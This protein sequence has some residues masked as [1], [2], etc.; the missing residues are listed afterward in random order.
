[1]SV[2]NKHQAS[3]LRPQMTEVQKRAGTTAWQA[4]RTA[5][6]NASTGIRACLQKVACGPQHLH[7]YQYG[8]CGQ[9]IW[10]PGHA[11]AHMHG[12]EPKI[13][14]HHH[15]RPVTL[16]ARIHPRVPILGGFIGSPRP[17]RKMS[18]QVHLA[19]DVRS[20]ELLQC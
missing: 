10:L 3:G 8:L 4:E 17:G 14:L 6:D 2:D 19:F 11:C 18:M 16:Q 1:M 12:S 7:F 5:N 15:D 20:G 13:C 9:S